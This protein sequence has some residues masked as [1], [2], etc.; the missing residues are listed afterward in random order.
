MMFE[1]VHTHDIHIHRLHSLHT[2]MQTYVN[3]NINIQNTCRRGTGDAENAGSQRQKKRAGEELGKQRISR[4]KPRNPAK[5]RKSQN[6]TSTRSR[7]AKKP[8][9]HKAKKVCLLCV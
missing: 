3:L 7:K 4:Q 6:A 8:R 2:Y 1:E 9:S 5:S